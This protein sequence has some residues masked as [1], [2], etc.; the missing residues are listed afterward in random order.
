MEEAVAWK[1]LSGNE[2]GETGET[3]AHEVLHLALGE[4]LLELALLG[5]AKSHAGSS[6]VSFRGTRSISARRVDSP[7]HCVGVCGIF[8][9]PVQRAWMRWDARWARMAEVP[10]CVDGTAERE[11][12]GLTSLKN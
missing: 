7:G 1:S 3:Y 2:G 8:G 10:G 9:F 11:G 5:A 4:A 12:L 6:S